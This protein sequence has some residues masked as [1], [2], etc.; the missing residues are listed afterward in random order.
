MHEPAHRWLMQLYAW[1]GQRSAALRQYGECERLL[2]AEVGVPPENETTQL[3]KA[4]KAKRGPPPPARARLTPSPPAVLGS[5]Y[6]LEAVGQEAVHLPL[7]VVVL[8]GCDPGAALEL[9]HH[10]SRNRVTSRTKSLGAVSMA[11]CR[12]PGGMYLHICQV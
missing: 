6:R 12:C 5:R 3:Y 1:S 4:I 11:T 10:S 7:E 9:L 2:H 8:E